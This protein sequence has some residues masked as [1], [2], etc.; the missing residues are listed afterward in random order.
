[1]NC[2]SSAGT[3]EYPARARIS[4]A[5]IA[6]T[7]AAEG[8]AGVK[9]SEVTVRHFSLCAFQ[10]MLGVNLSRGPGGGRR[11]ENRT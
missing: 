7:I 11:T 1:M 10:H 8:R 3:I 2:G 4:A 6:P 5:Q 9:S